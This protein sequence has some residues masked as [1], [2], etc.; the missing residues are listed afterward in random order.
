MEIDKDTKATI[1]KLSP[2]KGDLLLVRIG[3]PSIGYYPTAE[4]LEAW[5]EALFT[6]IG[7]DVDA[8][9]Y[10][11]GTARFKL[12]HTPLELAQLLADE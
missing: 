4:T 5:K 12:V 11:N 2:Q 9:I 3:D 6:I 1:E 7:P 10:S 8:L